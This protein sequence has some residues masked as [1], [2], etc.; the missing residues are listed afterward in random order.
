MDE[1]FTRLLALKKMGL[2]VFDRQFNILQIDHYGE[3]I[4]RSIGDGPV[5]DNLLS[6]FPEFIGSEEVIQKI[7]LGKK[8]EYRLD[9]VNRIDDT[10]TTRYVHLLVLR[11]VESEDG[12]LVIE[13]VSEKGL[14]VQ[15]A[16]QQRYE[17]FLLKRDEEFRKKR[18]YDS[19]I[20]KS[21]A[22]KAVRDMVQKLRAA[23]RATVLIVGETGTG[24]SH[25]AGVIHESTTPTEVPFVEINC[26]ALPQHLIESELF[27]YEKGAFTHAI[28]AKPGLLEEARG[29]T[30]F[31]D[32]IGELPLNV[33]SKLLAALETKKFRRLGSTAMNDVNARFIAA[34]NRDLHKAVE[35]KIFREDLYYRLNV[36]ELNL[37]PLRMMGSDILLLA[38]HF[39]KMFNVELKKNV[40][41]LSP[42]AQQVLL[43]HAWLGNV[44]ELS[45]CL[46]RAMIFIETEYIEAT[47]LALFKRDS[48]THQNWAVP[49]G[50]IVL[51]DVERNLI[52]SALLQTG[53]NKSKAARL[54]GLSRDTLRYRMEKYGLE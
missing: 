29:G 1:N 16:N 8:K 7:L 15:Q 28:A 4:I 53:N 52:S 40:R 11:H 41:G 48:P 36:V 47:D 35:D 20:G 12:L 38:D 24:K 6:M 5:E 13:D 30:V 33:Q 34:T 14:A 19:I 45:N 23:P 22:I 3:K 31:L 21:P 18:L 49:P 2:L 50:G 9:Y 51:E 26:A 25:T 37:P 32:E 17:L 43:N 39:I 42:G 46:E 27:G 54:L 10:G 44:R